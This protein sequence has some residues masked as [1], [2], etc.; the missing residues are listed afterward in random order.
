M[1]LLQ[2]LNIS[3]FHKQDD[4]ISL[5]EDAKHLPV[6]FRFEGKAN[7]NCKLSDLDWLGLFEVGKIFQRIGAFLPPTT[8]EPTLCRLMS[9]GG[10]IDCDLLLV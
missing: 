1:G 8:D 10:T 9:A 3:A 7:L 4:S 5:L 2:V 6:E